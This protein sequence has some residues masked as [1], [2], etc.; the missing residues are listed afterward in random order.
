MIA[1][2]HNQALRW[3]F[4]KPDTIALEPLHDGPS[5]FIRQVWP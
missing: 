4:L 1:S 5:R 3:L 2:A